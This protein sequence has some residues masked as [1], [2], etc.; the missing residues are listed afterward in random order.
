MISFTVSLECFTIYRPPL[1]VQG[2]TY[3]Q[4]SQPLLHGTY[5]TLKWKGPPEHPFPP[6][7]ARGCQFALIK[8]C[9]CSDHYLIH[10]KLFVNL[11]CHFATQKKKSAST[12]KS[13]HISQI[14]RRNWFS[15][16]PEL[17]A[18]TAKIVSLS[19]VRQGHRKLDS[20]TSRYSWRIL[21]KLLFYCTY[22]IIL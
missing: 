8:S 12:K 17:S 21:C 5:V 10:T 9:L 1:G 20:N 4:W 3:R 15:W 19:K 18:L 2:T 11:P 22:L 6:P 7:Q 14:V 16:V 13:L